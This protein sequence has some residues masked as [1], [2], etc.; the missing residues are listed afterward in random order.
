MNGDELTEGKSM[1]Y[2]KIRGGNKLSG[3]V[4][5]TSAK[6]A[7]LPILASTVLTKSD[8]KIKNCSRLTDVT[9]M[10]NIIKSITTVEA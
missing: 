5:I 8:V 2:F 4:E 1:E 9:A 10:L 6:N 7:V 3:S